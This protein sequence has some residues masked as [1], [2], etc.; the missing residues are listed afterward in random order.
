[1][2]DG[3]G[4]GD[5]GAAGGGGGTAGNMTFSPT[6]P[7]P[8]V[9]PGSSSEAWDPASREQRVLQWI[10]PKSVCG[11]L[12]GKNGSRIKLINESSGAWVKIAHHEEVGPDVG[13]SFIYIR[14]TA[15]QTAQALLMVQRIA[16]GRPH[17]TSDAD[18]ITVNVPYRS[19]RSIIDGEPYLGIPCLDEAVAYPNLTIK[20]EAPLVTG[21]SVSKIIVKGGS[22]EHQSEA[23]RVINERLDKW[24]SEHVFNES[25]SP[26]DTLSA[27]PPGLD[28]AGARNP[29]EGSTGEA[30]KTAREE[31]CLLIL[32]SSESAEALQRLDDEGKSC[33]SP[34]TDHFGVLLEYVPERTL[35][36]SFGPSTRVLALQGHLGSILL[37]IEPIHTLLLQHGYLT[38]TTVLSPAGPKV[39]TLPS[40]GSLGTGLAVDSPIPHAPASNHAP[41]AAPGASPG[42]RPRHNKG[43]QQIVAQLQDVMQG[44]RQ[45]EQC[46]EPPCLKLLQAYEEFRLA[47]GNFTPGGG[48]V[49]GAGAAGGGHM[50]GQGYG[51]GGN[52]GNGNGNGNGAGG[53]GGHGHQPQSAALHEP[54]PPREQQISGHAAL[55]MGGMGSS[56]R[57]YGTSVG[58]MTGHYSGGSGGGVT[59]HHHHNQHQHQQ[60]Q[61]M[62]VNALLY[63]ASPSSH[64]QPSYGEQRGAP[65]YN[66]NNNN[67]NNNNTNNNKNNNNNNNNNNNSNNSNY[68][69]YSNYNNNNNNNNSWSAQNPYSRQSQGQGQGQG[70]GPPQPPHGSPNSHPDP[71]PNPYSQYDEY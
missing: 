24:K 35:S 65:R 60:E 49:G 27:L 25:H 29:M 26:V 38:T 1:M 40:S 62:G 71:H 55:T 47:Y 67:N 6:Q 69:N 32:V 48:L 66:N 19:L 31:S 33:Y 21:V 44:L 15:A 5:E 13:E 17:K 16:G 57:A 12:I 54:A 43:F 30:T 11:V 4:Q 70:R 45:Y 7:V 3:V 36:C 37:A 8:S 50:Q 2:T 51:V 34:I 14:G 18:S 22:P 53:G 39:L 23:V 42:P 20:T 63:G 41:L 61:P 59:S 10:I 28:M 52:G 46:T 56:V 58:N 64:Q 68:S 9:G